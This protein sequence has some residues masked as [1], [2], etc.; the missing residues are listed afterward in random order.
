MRKIIVRC[1]LDVP[2]E[3]DDN[4]YDDEFTAEFDLEDNHCPGTGLV[5][6]AIDEAIKKGDKNGFCWA[7]AL[8]GKCEI[9]EDNK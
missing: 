8:K 7:C 2:I 4:H 3:V 9:I 6:V 1:T 5:G